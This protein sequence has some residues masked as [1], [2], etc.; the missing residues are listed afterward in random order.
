MLA[1]DVGHPG[2]AFRLSQRAQNLLLGMPFF[3]T[4]GS[5]SIA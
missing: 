5:S 3:A 2:A 4:F 1:A